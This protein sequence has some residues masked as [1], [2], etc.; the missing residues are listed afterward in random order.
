MHARGP[1]LTSAAQLRHKHLHVQSTEGPQLRTALQPAEPREKA[2]LPAVVTAKVHDQQPAAHTSPPAQAAVEAA[3][4]E[5]PEDNQVL[6]AFASNNWISLGTQAFAE[7]CAEWTCCE[8]R[9]AS[10]MPP[11]WRV[12]CWQQHGSCPVLTGAEGRYL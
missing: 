10:S 1:S 8:T 4:R 7:M 5:S 12:I 6:P 9:I 11:S 3:Q 2:A